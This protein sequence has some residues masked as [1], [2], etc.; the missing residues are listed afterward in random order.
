V[1]CAPAAQTPQTADQSGALAA[2]AR[3]RKQQHPKKW[4]TN[5]ESAHYLRF[6]SSG[7]NFAII[8]I[9]LESAPSP[10]PLPQ[11]GHGGARLKASRTSDGLTLR[12]ACL[13][14]NATMMA[15]H[16]GLPLNRHITVHWAAAG[17]ADHRAAKATTA[18]LKYL[19]DWLG[20]GTAYV[21]VRENGDSKGTHLHILAH[22]PLGRRMSGARS[23][24]WLEKI[25][26]QSYRPGTIMTRCIAGHRAPDGPIYA[27]NLHAA[28]DY[29]RKGAYPD[30]AAIIGID[31]ESGGRIIG[32]RCGTSRNI[33]IGTKSR[34]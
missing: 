23:R 15:A 33:G 20:G 7:A 28:L 5:V 3:S 8:D 17:V 25:T 1:R 16:I 11:A 9:G 22:I 13:L 26:G 12:Q 27:A 30:A 18:F 19:R 4:E 29:I 31:H 24:R 34:I 10:A 32:K 14:A 21:W 2:P 6:A